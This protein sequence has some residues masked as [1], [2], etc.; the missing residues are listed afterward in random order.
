MARTAGQVPPPNPGPV[1]IDPPPRPPAGDHEKLA[2]LAIRGR[3]QTLDPT[4]LPIGKHP[5]PRHAHDNALRSRPRSRRHALGES[6]ARAPANFS[7]VPGWAAASTA[8]PCS[9][10]VRPSHGLKENALLLLD[11][12]GEFQSFAVDVLLDGLTDDIP[13]RALRGRVHLQGL[14]RELRA[15][16]PAVKPSRSEA[17]DEG[18]RRQGRGLPEPPPAPPPPPS[19]APPPPYGPL[20]PRWRLPA[21]VAGTSLFRPGN[22]RLGVGLVDRAAR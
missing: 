20:G 18:P 17:S 2:P 12:A 15:Y 16:A 22:V 6:H 19:P 10:L 21:L 14:A 13:Q 5:R 8:R 3:H 1:P 4:P 9:R 11:G 7:R